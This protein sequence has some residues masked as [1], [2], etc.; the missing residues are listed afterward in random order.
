MVI[1]LK[2]PLLGNLLFIGVGVIAGQYAPRIIDDYID[3]KFTKITINKI[4]N[5]RSVSAICGLISDIHP[6]E[7]NEFMD[8]PNGFI[9]TVGQGNYKLTISELINKY[10]LVHHH[11]DYVN[12][13]MEK[14]IGLG[15]KWVDNSNIYDTM[16]I[17]INEANIIVSFYYK[18]SRDNIN[19]ILEYAYN[20]YS[21]YTEKSYFKYSDGNEWGRPAVRNPIKLDQTI[22]MF[23]VIDSIDEYIIKSGGRSV[24]LMFKGKPGT[25]KSTAIE[26]LAARYRRTC[27]IVLFNSNKLDDGGLIKLCNTIP[28]NS[29][30]VFEEFEKQLE[31]INNNNKINVSKTGILLA[32]DGP[33]RLPN[34]TILIIT[35]NDDTPI[36]KMF[37]NTLKEG[38]RIDKVFNF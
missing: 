25:G 27:H 5:Y 16:F 4:Q 20:Q 15:F 13:I 6:E 24:K 33:S 17:E 34:G 37:G 11:E 10:D 12:S 31:L 21:S 28:P 29:I 14:I 19:N 8:G 2:M 3:G 32:I 35:C 36:R 30:I 38:R 18:L 23:P 1:N 22:K 7:R 9:H 26:Y